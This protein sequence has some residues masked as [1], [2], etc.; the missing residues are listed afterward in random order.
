MKLVMDSSNITNIRQRAFTLVELLVVIAIIGILVALLLPAV[1]GTREA[2][3]NIQCKNNLKQLGLAAK[4]HVAIHGHFPSGGWGF[5][6]IGDPNRGYGKSQ[7]GGWTYNTLPY[8]EQQ[9]VHDI[10]LGMEGTYL[11]AELVKLQSAVV[12]GFYCPTRR[13]PAPYPGHDE[14]YNAAFPTNGYAKTDYAGNGGLSIQVNAGPPAGSS[15]PPDPNTPEYA[16][17]LNNTGLTHLISQVR[18]AH[19]TDGLSSTYWVCEKNLRPEDYFSRNTADNGS[20]YQ[21]HDW[22]NI[23]WVLEA[24]RRDQP[25]IDWYKSFGSAHASGFNAV[26][27][28]GSVHTINFTVD[29]QVHRR[30]G[31]RKDG[32]PVDLGS[33]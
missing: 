20:L 16:W 26:M 18:P 1:Q 29:S 11:K 9:A 6:W 28:D 22:D 10:G 14:A 13:R 4:S 31:N 15:S 25:G 7:P 23:R 27:C 19:I 3:R 33:L 30:L 24:P 8:L 12:A 32:E 17:V 2:A 5:R 21:G